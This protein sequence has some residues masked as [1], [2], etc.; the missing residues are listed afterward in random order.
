VE[1]KCAIRA[2]SVVDVLDR[3]LDKG[4]VIDTWVRVSVVGVDL[5]TVEARVV[6]AAFETHT[7]YGE[8]ISRVA[9]NANPPLRPAEPT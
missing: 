2:V 8:R 5:P 3:I 9:P 1:E 6:V 4:I 7:T